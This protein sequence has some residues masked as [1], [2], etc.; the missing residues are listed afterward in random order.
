[1]EQMSAFI[2]EMMQ[3]KDK[4]KAGATTLEV[5]RHPEKYISAKYSRRLSDLE[6]EDLISHAA[7]SGNFRF[8]AKWKIKNQDGEGIYIFVAPRTILELAICSEI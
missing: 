4:F 5:I 2:N 6:L 8:D 7:G 1:E 3:T